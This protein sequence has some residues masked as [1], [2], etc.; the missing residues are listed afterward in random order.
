[1]RDREPT[2]CPICKK[3]DVIKAILGYPSLEDFNTDN[4]YLIGYISDLTIDRTWACKNCD[5]EFWKDI[6]RKSSALGGNFG[7]DHQKKGLKKKKRKK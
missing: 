5:A 4:I 3:K 6:L 7:N 1:M 2:I